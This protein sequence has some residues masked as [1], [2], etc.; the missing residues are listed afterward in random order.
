MSLDAI[1]TAH[2]ADVLNNQTGITIA[3]VCGNPRTRK[4][5]RAY[6]IDLHASDASVVR[7]S[8]QVFELD[9]GNKVMFNTLTPNILRGHRVHEIYLVDVPEHKQDELQSNL[10]VNMCCNDDKMYC[11]TWTDPIDIQT[12][13][14]QNELRIVVMDSELDG[15]II[16]QGLE[17]DLCVQGRNVDDIVYG[18]GLQLDYYLGRSNLFDMNGQPMPRENVIESIPAAPDEFFA[19]WDNQTGIDNI[20]LGY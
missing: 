7:N 20:T 12:Y 10:L 2:I 19:M 6:I 14:P 18:I 15:I 8:Q 9:N 16:G 11:V 5:L 4:K 3:I 13:P 17:L 1:H